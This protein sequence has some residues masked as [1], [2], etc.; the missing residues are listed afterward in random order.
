MTKK[1]W[2]LL[3]VLAGVALSATSFDATAQSTQ[4]YWGS[5]AGIV[6]KSS[7]GLCWRSGAWT[8]AMA[9]AECDPDLVKKPEPKPMAAP[10]P[11]PPPAPAP[12]PKHVWQ[13]N[14]RKLFP[15]WLR[16]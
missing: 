9:T 16:P 15:Q 13:E 7:A 1:L 5:T 11:A 4:G 2:K 3:F 10:M 8:P 12:M 6:W 14:I